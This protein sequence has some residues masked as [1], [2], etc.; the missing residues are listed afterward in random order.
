MSERLEFH[1]TLHEWIMALWYEYVLGTDPQERSYDDDTFMVSFVST[2]F[3]CPVAP[4]G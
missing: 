4:K 1:G 2:F 3:R